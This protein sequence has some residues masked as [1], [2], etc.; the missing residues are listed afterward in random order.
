MMKFIDAN[1]FIERWSNE[2]VREFTE[3]L[4]REEHCTSVLVLAEV[5]HK[6][7]KKRIVHTFDYLRG[8]MGAIKVF[9]IFQDD[10]FQAMKSF[11]NMGINDRLH[12]AVMKRNAISVIVSFDRDFDGEKNIIREEIS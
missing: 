7:Q 11:P 4:N 1:I 9:D 6:L 2:K 3:S 10:F 12:L 5:Y 8:I